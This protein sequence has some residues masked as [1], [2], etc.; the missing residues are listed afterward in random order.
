MRVIK[1]QQC[2]VVCQSVHKTDRSDAATIAGFLEADMLTEAE[3]CSQGNEWRRR[4]LNRRSLAVRMIVAAKNQIHG[5]LTGLGMTDNKASSQ[6]KKGR[7]MPVR[8]RNTN[9]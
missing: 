2:K 5:L 1:P 9:W 6:S 7:W 4:L 8:E 3:L